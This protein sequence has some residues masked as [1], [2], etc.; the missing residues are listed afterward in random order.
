MCLLV[1]VR[2][3]RGDL[4]SKV[5]VEASFRSRHRELCS[6]RVRKK[7]RTPYMFIMQQDS[8]HNTKDSQVALRSWNSAFYYQSRRASLSP[9]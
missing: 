8:E 1:N 7:V 2:D 5:R 9:P 4:A 3:T 6:V